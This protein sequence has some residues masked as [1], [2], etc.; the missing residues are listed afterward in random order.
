M[1]CPPPLVDAD[2][3]ES[4]AVLPAALAIC[5]ATKPVRALNDSSFFAASKPAANFW[6][7]KTLF[8]TCS[9]HK[10]NLA[11]IASQ[12]NV[13]PSHVTVKGKSKQAWKS[14]HELVTR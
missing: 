7:I 2:G 9:L 6:S 13:F 8:N 11:F 10:I 4:A 14:T 5:V 12:E 3:F 1:A